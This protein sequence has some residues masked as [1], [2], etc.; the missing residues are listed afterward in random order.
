M[1]VLT[2]SGVVPP[3]VAN[4]FDRKL[5]K[6]ALPKLHHMRMAQRRPLSRRN[7]NT[8]VFRRLEALALATTPLVEGVPPA[9]RQ[10]SNTDVNCTIQQWGDYVTL[11]DLVQATVEHPLL[12]DTNRLLGEQAGQTIDALMRDVAAAGTNVFYG[13]AVGARASLT[14]TTHKVDTDLLDRVARD[15]ENSNSMKFTE[16]VSATTKVSTFGIRESFWGITHPFVQFT[17]QDL[18]GYR[19]TEEY[20]S[21]GPVLP[22]EIGAYKNQRFLSTTQAKK[23][24]GG[25]G[26]AAGDVKSTGGSA[27]VYTILT[28]ATDAVGA[29]PL[30]GMSLQNIIKPLGSSGTGDPLNQISTSGWKHT[31]CRIRLNENFMARSEVT[32]GNNAP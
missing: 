15:L 12:N 19:S 7:G 13:G 20:G 18:T 8:M 10:I 3:A 17:L 4:F 28:F 9:G 16:M 6:R 2:D 30:E 21:T 27:D 31:G 11:S 32:V 1:G 26:A 5:L 29:V 14:T 25:G 22:G 23:F 24:L